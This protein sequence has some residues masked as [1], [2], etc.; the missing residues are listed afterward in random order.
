MA[1]KIA[2]R[3]ARKVLNSAGNHLS[4]LSSYTAFGG[5]D[6]QMENPLRR[7]HST[8]QIP[9][10]LSK[11]LKESAKAPTALVSTGKKSGH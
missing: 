7:L 8:K 2:I 6:S 11:N 5:L 4:L 1:I 10:F 9:T 3:Y